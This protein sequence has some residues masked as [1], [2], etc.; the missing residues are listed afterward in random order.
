MLDFH[1]EHASLSPLLMQ[2]AQKI[3]LEQFDSSK[4][5]LLE[6]EV[7]GIESLSEKKIEKGIERYKK[8]DLTDFIALNVLVEKAVERSRRWREEM[9]KE[10]ILSTEGLQPV[11]GETY[12]SYAKNRQQLRNRVRKQLIRIL[13]KEKEESTQQAWTPMKREK[14]FS[15]WESRFNRSEE[16]YLSSNK[17]G[18]HQLAYHTLKALAKSLDAHTAY[19]SPE[20][21][22]EM[23]ISL[24]K[25]FY[26]VGI[27]LKETID[28]VMISNLIPGGPAEKSGQVE[29]GDQ[30]IEINGKS[31]KEMSYSEILISLKGDG[32][33]GL[34]LKL[35]SRESGKQK[36]VFLKQEKIELLEERLQ[37]TSHPYGDGHIGVLTLSSFYEGESAASAE[38]DMREAL[39]SLKKAGPLKGVILDMRENAGGFLSQAVKVAGLFITRGVVVISKYS[40]GE[41]KYLRN[42][43]GTLHFDGPLIV[44]T[45]KASASAAEIVAQALQDYGAALIVGDPHTYGKG[46][47]QYQTV[48]DPQAR[49]FYKVTVGRYYTVSGRSTQIEGVQ[50]DIVVPTIFSPYK[51]G[52]RFLDYPL[53][54]DTVAAAY[55][56]PLTDV[57]FRNRIWFQKNYL[58]NLH[59]PQDRWQ[60]ALPTLRANSERRIEKDKNFSLFLKQQG[61]RKRRSPRSFQRICNPAWGHEDLQ[62]VEAI[63][64]MKDLILCQKDSA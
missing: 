62:V 16:R 2:R 63:N 49:V 41:I 43:D 64:I 13:S 34:T 40:D 51:I 1:V 8:N 42:L 5:Y 44:L 10:L 56:D 6:D 35:L 29:I 12:L 9:Q 22:L 25:E 27:A 46:T 60:R 47:I 11:H 45:S 59:Q 53:T 36:E 39:K 24:N 55:V 15:F 28:G 4:M 14:I 17:I 20:E 33:S 18:E 31:V 58:P 3:Y 19:F 38:A 23:R 7:K 54:S 26:G 30:I 37:Y 21:A 50:A 52:E 61:E 32:K 48:T 57:D